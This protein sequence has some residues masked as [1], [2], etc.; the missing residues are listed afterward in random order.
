MSIANYR[1]PLSGGLALATCFQ[2]GSEASE[3]AALCAAFP[4]FCIR[5]LSLASA[6]FCRYLSQPLTA[7]L[8]D[9]RVYRRCF[10]SI[11][12]ASQNPDSPNCRWFNSLFKWPRHVSRQPR[13]SQAPRATPRLS[14]HPSTRPAGLWRQRD[15]RDARALRRSRSRVRRGNV[16]SFSSPLAT[17][18]HVNRT[19]LNSCVLRSVEVIQTTVQNRAASCRA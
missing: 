2:R 16:S 11:S 12:Q 7:V 9:R 6:D 3:N 19:P 4:H 8:R 18:H 10:D 17:A 14:P 13:R 5:G 1:R 15:C